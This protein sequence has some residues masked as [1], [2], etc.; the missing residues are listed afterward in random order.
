MYQII[1][2]PILF[3]M[4][5]LAISTLNFRFPSLRG[6]WG[7]C[8]FFI[9][10]V[11]VWGQFHI[12]EEPLFSLRDA[13]SLEADDTIAENAKPKE[14]TNIYIVAGT[15]TYNLVESPTVEITYL[16][17]EP[18]K[19]KKITV[20]AV[21]QP[22]KEHRPDI[23]EQKEKELVPEVTIRSVPGY[24]RSYIGGSDPLKL[25]N[26]PVRDYRVKTIVYEFSEMISWDSSLKKQ[27]T[28]NTVLSD[29]SK[30]RSQNYLS[31]PPPDVFT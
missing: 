16:A 26:L 6:G 5:R 14:K 31:R 25:I 29:I 4:N 2:K 20:L 24:P 23:E 9:F 12:P 13:P 30:Y 21:R 17:T 15:K 18:V 8:L 7:I 27:F 1:P 3:F 19:E 10:P 28:E 11:T 22:E